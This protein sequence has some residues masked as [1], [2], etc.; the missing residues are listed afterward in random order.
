M[1]QNELKERKEKLSDYNGDFNLYTKA[2]QEIIPT[3]IIVLNNYESFVEN[4]PN[5]Y[6][7]ILEIY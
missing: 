7:E 2:T 3:F 5:S 4:Y 1:L 6:E